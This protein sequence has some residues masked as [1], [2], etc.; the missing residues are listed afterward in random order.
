MQVAIQAVL[1]F[2]PESPERGL[3][4]GSE[5]RAPVICPKPKTRYFSF[6]TPDCKTE[7]YTPTLQTVHSPERVLLG[8]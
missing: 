2:K 6:K 4:G 5:D 7:P 8:P 3:D 1:L